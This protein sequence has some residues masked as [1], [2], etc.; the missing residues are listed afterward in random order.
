MSGGR[1][2]IATA[3]RNTPSASIETTRNSCSFIDIVMAFRFVR[4]QIR[5]SRRFGALQWR[6]VFATTPAF[7]CT[8]SA[9]GFS[10]PR[11][12]VCVRQYLS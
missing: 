9:P 11:I 12:T 1:S 5:R 6:M 7:S 3:C 2:V 4:V 8:S 10:W